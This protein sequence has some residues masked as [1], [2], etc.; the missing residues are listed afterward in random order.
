MAGMRQVPG[1]LHIVMIVGSL[2][3]ASGGPLWRRMSVT[4]FTWLTVAFAIVIVM[5]LLVWLAGPRR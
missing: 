5:W 2:L 3:L 4:A 1:S